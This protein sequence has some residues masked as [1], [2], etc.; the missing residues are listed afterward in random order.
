MRCPA[1]KRKLEGYLAGTLD[2][3]TRG[4]LDLHLGSCA[5]CQSEL[6]RAYKVWQALESDESADPGSGFNRLLWA[7]IDS[8]GTR[9]WVPTLPRLAPTV[10]WTCAAAVA[11]L[12]GGVTGK[13]IGRPDGVTAPART[14]AAEWPI[15]ALDRVPAESVGGVYAQL[16]AD[17]GGDKR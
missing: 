1:A 8:A 13:E 10:V 4:S 2:G 17:T 6:A 9:G 12:L 16:I 11:V 5:R 7:K 15:A 3:R 14:I